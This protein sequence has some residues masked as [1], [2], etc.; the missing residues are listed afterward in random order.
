MERYRPA[1][2]R[3][4][5][6]VITA[7]LL[8]GY[9]T[10]RW[11]LGL[12]TIDNYESRYVFIT[13]CDSGFG[14]LLAKRLDSMGFN[15][16]AGCL[17][18]EGA[19]SLRKEVSPRLVTVD[20]DVT[21]E[22]KIHDAFVFVRDT[23][24]DKTG[25][26]AVVN[27]AGIACD[28]G[29]AEWFPRS[30]YERL[31]AVN[32]YGMIDVCRTF[33]PLIR[34]QHGRIV[35]C[36]SLSGRFA[37]GV[38]PYCVSKYGVE[39]YSDCLRRDLYVEGITVHMIEPLTFKTPMISN[40]P[41]R[42]RSAFERISPEMQAFYGQTYLEQCEVVV[43]KTIDTM[44]NPNTYLVVDDYVHAIT[45]RF[46]RARY[47]PGNYTKYLLWVVWSLPEWIVDWMLSLMLPKPAGAK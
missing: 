44:V 42:L 41:Q 36:S 35:N 5:L 38:A 6:L 40:L 21:S 1:V 12:S 13:G 46:P 10:L 34:K 7:G 47:M 45:S 29:P 23:L 43:R 20:I 25:L 3:M 32:V 26:W 16:F 18:D 33:L 37:V 15:V 30:E 31:M 11:L 9:C 8:I 19:E 27:N 14:N 24:P 28:P 4:F 39:A 2:S 22:K 17:T